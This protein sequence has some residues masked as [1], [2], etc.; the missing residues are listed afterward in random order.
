VGTREYEGTSSST[1]WQNPKPR[2]FTLLMHR[3]E[4]RVRT[5]AA[6]CLCSDS[7]R[8]LQVKLDCRVER[9]VEEFLRFQFGD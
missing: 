8:F 5:T 7:E 4:G 6:L 3:R 1:V 2:K 9:L